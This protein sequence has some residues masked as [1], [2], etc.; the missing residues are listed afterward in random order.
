MTNRYILTRENLPPRKKQILEDPNCPGVT[1]KEIKTL[2]TRFRQDRMFEEAE[3]LI[4]RYKDL[5][6]Y[7]TPRSKIYNSKVKKKLDSNERILAI[8][9]FK[10]PDELHPAEIRAL[11]GN[12]TNEEYYK[13]NWAVY[14]LQRQNKMDKVEELMDK[15]KDVFIEHKRQLLKKK[16]QI[17]EAIIDKLD[18]TSLDVTDSHID[19]LTPFQWKLYNDPEF[20]PSL[21]SLCREIHDLERILDLES[22]TFLCEKYEN[23][24]YPPA[25]GYQGLEL[26]DEEVQEILKELN[27]ENALA[28][29]MSKKK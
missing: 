8:M 6:E 21:R 9:P 28:E 10:D 15:Y 12:L 11:T 19:G 22:L 27:G 25:E 18:L 5:I 4:E 3:I 1:K 20:I 23:I 2:I 26:N 17:R 29:L 13:I 7:T 24:L 16:F 14:S